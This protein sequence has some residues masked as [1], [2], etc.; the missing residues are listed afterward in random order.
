M[1]E[2]LHLAREALDLGVEHAVP[3]RLDDRVDLLV[4]AL[5]QDRLALHGRHGGPQLRGVAGSG[6]AGGGRDGLG[7]AG[8]VARGV[9]RH[10]LVGHAQLRCVTRHGVARE[11]G[12]GVDG[13]V[14]ALLIRLAQRDLRDVHKVDQVVPGVGGGQLLLMVRGRSGHLISLAGVGLNTAPVGPILGLWAGL[15]LG[16]TL[17]RV[18]VG[19]QGQR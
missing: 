14:E 3:L 15:L 16:H 10:R 9:G 5:V 13:G 11:A 12:L 6:E 8:G 1:G 19:D 7:V 17:K 4:D 18:R 2:L